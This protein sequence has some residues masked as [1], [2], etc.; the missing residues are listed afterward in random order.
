MDNGAKRVLLPTESKRALFDAP[1]DV[2]DK[3]Q[4]IF[5]SDPVNATFRAMG[6]D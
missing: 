1:G 6:L 2:L 5:F 3:L 4:I